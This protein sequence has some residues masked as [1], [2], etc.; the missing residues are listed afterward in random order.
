[1]LAV[2]FA[3]G[4]VVCCLATPFG[5]LSLSLLTAAALEA[6]SQKGIVHRDLKPQNILL[7]HAEH[8]S[9]PLPSE[10]TLKIGNIF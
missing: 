1:M 6:L 4:G 3:L 5:D 10:I 2:H 9:N 7:C 8:Q